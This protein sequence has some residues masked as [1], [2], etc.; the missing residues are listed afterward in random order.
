MVTGVVSFGGIVLS[1]VI[2]MAHNSPFLSTVQWFWCVATK[3]DCV[4]IDFTMFLLPRDTAQVI[5][6]KDLYSHSPGRLLI[7]SVSKDL[8]VPDIAHKWNLKCA[9]M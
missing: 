7:S 9:V 5:I 1:T 2:H 6:S 3:I 4:A 8:L